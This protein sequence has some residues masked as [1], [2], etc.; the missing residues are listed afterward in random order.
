[1][2]VAAIDFESKKRKKNTD[3][4]S[5]LVD[6]DNNNIQSNIETN[7]GENNVISIFKDILINESHIWPPDT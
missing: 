2:Y 5:V 4:Q 1:M 3:N 6:E 7:V